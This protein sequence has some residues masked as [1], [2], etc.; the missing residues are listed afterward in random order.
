[1]PD[2]GFERVDVGAGG[3]AAV[4]ANGV[5]PVR[6]TEQFAQ[7][8]CPVEP[9]VALAGVAVEVAGGEVLAK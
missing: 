1:M 9:L 5:E 2:A 4:E 6:P 8:G 3:V 7:Y